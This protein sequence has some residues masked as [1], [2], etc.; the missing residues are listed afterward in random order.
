M[1]STKEQ[2]TE[3]ATQPGMAV[4]EAKTAFEML[5]GRLSALG[6]DELLP[7]RV[8]IQL[9]AAVAHS[10]AHRDSAKVRRER[11]ERLAAAGMFDM[12]HLDD[13]LL[14]A[15]AAWHARR[16]QLQQEALASQAAVTEL[17][18]K[19][20]QQ[21]RARMLRVLEHCFAD[22]P[23]VGPELV[24]IRA[25]TGYQDLANDLLAVADLYDDPAIYAVV[26]RDPVHYRASDPAAAR[27]AAAAIFTGIGQTSEGEAA[28]WT[29]LTQ[30]AW[31]LLSRSYDELR[32]AGR[33][34]F[35][36]DEDVEMTYPSLISV[37]RAAPTRAAA[38]PAVAPHVP[39][40]AAPAAAAPVAAAPHGSPA[41]P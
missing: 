30:R 28:R 29:E 25:G 7:V 14:L 2:Q 37:V 31:T 21:L 24:A 38:A 26:Q 33:F 10:L 11:L 18:V 12:K 13:L 41:T 1:A 27:D 6:R 36:H 35:R 20:A 34:A 40:A 19:G 3:N 9:V 22:D 8:D 23:K 32:A 16:Q 15:L 4:S 5:E 39:P 17:V